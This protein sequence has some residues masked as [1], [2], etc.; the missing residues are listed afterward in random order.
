MSERKW[1][2]VDMGLEAYV[3]EGSS[4]DIRDLDGT[5]LHIGGSPAV[6]VRETAAEEEIAPMLRKAEQPGN[7]L[8][9]R[10]RCGWRGYTPVVSDIL[11]A[12]IAEMHDRYGGDALSEE[13]LATLAIYWLGEWAK[14]A[15]VQERKLEGE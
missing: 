3:P 8:P 2:R 5:I 13:E 7:L 4:V 11:E 10:Y 12:V 6:L 14:R 9:L 15:E 1:E